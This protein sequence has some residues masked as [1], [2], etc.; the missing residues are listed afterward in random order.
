VIPR[1]CSL[2]CDLNLIHQ[3]DP[4]RAASVHAREDLQPRAQSH[5]AVEA[6]RARNIN[7]QTAMPSAP[8]AFFEAVRAFLASRSKTRIYQGPAPATLLAL[9]RR[10]QKETPPSIPVSPYGVAKL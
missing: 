3:S 4:D 9:V 2:T 1:R 5:V 8:C 6:S 10:P 7:R